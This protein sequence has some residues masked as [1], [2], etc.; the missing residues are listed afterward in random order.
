[1]VYKKN[2]KQ[3]NHLTIHLQLLLSSSVFN[4]NYN[5]KKKKE[6]VNRQRTN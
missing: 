3:L 4:N 2:I 1:M 5:D 6:K